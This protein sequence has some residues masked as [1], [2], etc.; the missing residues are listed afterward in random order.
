MAIKPA[1]KRAFVTGIISSALVFSLILIQPLRSEEGASL[2][3][4]EPIDTV[5]IDPGHGGRDPGAVGPGD[6]Y[7]KD[8]VLQVSLKAKQKLEE[9]GLKVILTREKDEFLGLQE[10]AKVANEAGGDIFISIHANA[11]PHGGWGFETYFLSA[12]ASDD[13]A[14]KTAHKENRAVKFEVG[15]GDLPPEINSDLEAILFDMAQSEYLRE[16]EKLALTIQDRLDSLLDSPNRGVKQAPFLVLMGATMPAVLVEI[17]FVSNEK[18]LKRLTDS[19]MQHSIAG[20]LTDSIQK[21]VQRRTAQMGR[22]QPEKIVQ[23]GG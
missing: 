3:P 1:N 11:S 21:F 20:A 18:E 6:V 2:Q 10:R 19:K 7:E 8:V 15:A 23:S 5:V 22:G 14:R 12:T 13:E 4:P 17:G 16:S 9:K